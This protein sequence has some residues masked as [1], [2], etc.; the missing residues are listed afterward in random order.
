MPFTQNPPARDWANLNDAWEDLHIDWLGIFD[1]YVE[2]IIGEITPFQFRWDD[3]ADTWAGLPNTWDTI[4]DPVLLNPPPSQ[5]SA[6]ITEQTFSMSASRG[7]NRDLQRTNAGLLGAQLRNETRIFDPLANSPLNRFLRPRVPVTIR[8]DGFNAFTGLINDWDF[9]YDVGGQSVASIAGADAFTLF[10]RETARGSAVAE[11]S[12]D[13]VNKVL[14]ELSVPFPVERRVIDAG[15]ATLHA[16]GYEENALTYL[17][18]IEESEGGLIFMGKEGVFRFQQRLTQPEDEVTQFTD[19]GVGLPYEN[20]EITFGTDLLANDVIVES[21]D[22]LVTAVNENSRLEN[23]PAELNVSS[24]LAGASLQG[25]A[26]FLLFKFG[27]PEYRIAAVTV[28]LSGLTLEQ[29][30]EILR[31]ELGSQ[32]EV[33]FTPNKIGDPI[34]IR[35]RIIGIS[36]DIAIEQHRVTFSFE[37]LGFAFFILDNDPA[38][39]LD[40]IDF[41]LGF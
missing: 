24:I 27:V 35:N 10:A 13:R 16:A 17:Q 23:G 19:T 25:L 30:A 26:D 40:N 41:V 4:L 36:H 39:K 31:L 11:S 14:N 18:T 3:L 1:P 28:N 37:A 6:N 8:V 2:L 15:N 12:G 38:G 9:N 22:G 21:V 33:I 34:S 5:T 7:R 20:I 32:A 29:R